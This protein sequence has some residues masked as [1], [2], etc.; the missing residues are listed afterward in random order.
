MSGWTGHGPTTALLNKGL[1]PAASPATPSA[2]RSSHTKPRAGG[3]ANE[4]NTAPSR[5]DDETGG[6]VHSSDDTDGTAAAINRAAKSD[7]GCCSRRN[8]S[9]VASSNCDSKTSSGPSVAEC[10]D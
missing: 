1:K 4:R 2:W 5:S 10:G 9:A 3:Q 8:V 7:S 6:S